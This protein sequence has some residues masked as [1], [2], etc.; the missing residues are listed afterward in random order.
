MPEVTEAHLTGNSLYGEDF[1]ADEIAR[2]YQQEETAFLGLLKDH[3]GIA[4]SAGAYDYEYAA[5][6]RFHAIDALSNRHFSCCVALGCAAGA[7]VE[8]LAPVVDRFVAIEPAE[9]WWRE[10]IGGK[11]ATYLKPTILGDIALDTGS[12]DLATSFGVLHHIPNVSHVVGEIA[13]V[14]QPG[15]LFLVREPI[16]WMGDWRR[17]R[18]GLTSNERGVP[19]AWFER[20]VQQQG[21]QILRRR[22]CMLNAFLIIVNK[23]GVANPLAHRPIVFADWVLSEMLRWNLHYRRDSF[24]RKVAPSSAFW[25]LRR[26]PD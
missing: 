11:P 25:V 5:F 7:D 9:Q 20:T 12:A 2:W 15:G 10:E 8:P 19:L 22:L 21:F 26:L 14:L 24:A 16:S 23:L 13:R 18:P 3:Y 1:S 4:D 6:N 17:T